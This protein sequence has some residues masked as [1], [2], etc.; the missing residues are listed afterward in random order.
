VVFQGQERIVVVARI[1]EAH[2]VPLALPEEHNLSAHNFAVHILAARILEAIRL[3]DIPAE[4]STP[5]RQVHLL[6]VPIAEFRSLAEAIVVGLDLA[7]RS[8]VVASASSVSHPP[9]LAAAPH[10]VPRH[11]AAEI[12]FARLPDFQVKSDK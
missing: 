10:M 8:L 12:R 6:V 4:P 2:Q 9:E 7:S 3:A 1:V 11:L 5:D